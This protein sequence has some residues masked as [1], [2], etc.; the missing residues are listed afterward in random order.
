[1]FFISFKLVNMAKEPLNS[2]FLSFKGVADTRVHN[3]SPFWRRNL[4]V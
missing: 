4:Q 2:P 1:M 3:V